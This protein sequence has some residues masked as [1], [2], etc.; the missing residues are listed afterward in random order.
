MCHNIKK[1]QCFR[2]N[3]QNSEAV[4]LFGP[5][6]GSTLRPFLWLLLFCFIA[7]AL[8]I[9]TP[10]M[11]FNSANNSIQLSNPGEAFID[12][13]FLGCT[14]LHL[15]QRNLFFQENQILHKEFA[16]SNLH[17]PAQRWERLLFPIGGA[18]N[19]QKNLNS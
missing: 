3:N 17:I 1:I 4:S 8:G 19:L 5:G 7:E 2:T 6:Q 16:I 13:S 11:D 15:D 10:I 12:D 9:S 18:L 14:S